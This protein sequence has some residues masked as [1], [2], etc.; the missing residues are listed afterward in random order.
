M[1]NA[2]GS[3]LE[4]LPAELLEI[5]LSDLSAKE[6]SQTQRLSRFCK[7][8]IESR[9]KSILRSSIQQHE[10]RILALSNN[11]TNVVGLEIDEALQRYYN[12]PS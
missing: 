1:D 6:L 11:L 10:R 9:Q 7:A 2:T 4:R 12:Y 3:S 8:F 5:I